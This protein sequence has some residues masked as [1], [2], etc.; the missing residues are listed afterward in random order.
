[1][2]KLHNI[3]ILAECYDGKWQNT[4]MTSED[5]FPLNRMRLRNSSWNKVAKM[6]K[7][8]LLDEMLSSNIIPNGDKDLLRFTKFP[9]G[10]TT[11]LYLQVTKYANGSISCTL[12]GGPLFNRPVADIFIHVKNMKDL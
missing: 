5:G 1:M 2:L 6:S 9:I 10:N 7:N 4:V 3:K 8:H 12:L 11:M